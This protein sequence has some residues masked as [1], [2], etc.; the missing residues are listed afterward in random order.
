MVDTKIEMCFLH[1][2]NSSFNLFI[3]NGLIVFDFATKSCYD[4]ISYNITFR[5]HFQT[6][7]TLCQFTYVHSQL[8]TKTTHC[9]SHLLE[10]ESKKNGDK[11]H[12]PKSKVI[13]FKWASKVNHVIF[14][15]E[16]EAACPGRG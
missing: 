7:V 10:R 15:H 4:I 12:N 9:T 1:N 3:L 5:N 2:L 13:L 16:S 6:F 11:N 14:D 8:A